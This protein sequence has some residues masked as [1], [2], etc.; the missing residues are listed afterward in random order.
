MRRVDIG[1]RV[2]EIPVRRSRRAKK[3][4]IVVDELRKVEI[5]VPSSTTND[6][7]D[8]LLGIPPE[9]ANVALVPMGYPRG[10]WARPDRR[11]AAEVTFWERWGTT[12]DSRTLSPPGGPVSSRR[13]LGRAGPRRTGG[14]SRRVVGPEGQ[15]TDGGPVVQGR[16][17]LHLHAMRQLLHRP[18]GVCVDQPRGD[19]AAGGVFE[20]DAAG[21]G[22]EIL[23]Q[24][25]SDATNLLQRRNNATQGPRRRLG[26]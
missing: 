2:V 13:G 7:I 5:I 22:G 24:G 17:A 11:P 8:A 1:G 18:A 9:Y 26:R 6:E 19:R 21:D 23:P 4:R 25:Y 12:T 20:A 3:L 16:P 14:V 10:R 15:H